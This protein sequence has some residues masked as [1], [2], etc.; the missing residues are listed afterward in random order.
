MAKQNHEKLN[1]TIG[2]LAGKQGVD[3]AVLE[4]VKVGRK[5]GEGKRVSGV[6][7]ETAVKTFLN[8]PADGRQKSSGASAKKDG[9]K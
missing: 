2:E 9:E 6:V 4:G 5:W 7:F 8:S 3:R 1:P